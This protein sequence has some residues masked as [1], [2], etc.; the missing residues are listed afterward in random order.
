MAGEGGEG[1]LTVGGELGAG[2]RS[3]IPAVF[4]DIRLR[5]GRE[6]EWRKI[7][8]AQLLIESSRTAPTPD[9]VSTGEDYSG[10]CLQRRLLYQQMTSLQEKLEL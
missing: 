4:K 7:F 5:C 1:L 9:Y 8:F 3:L 10:E 6:H 2:P